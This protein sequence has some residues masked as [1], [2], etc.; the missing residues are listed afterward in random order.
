M[1]HS[2]CLLLSIFWSEAYSPLL[3]L[4]AS[5]GRHEVHCVCNARGIHVYLPGSW[6][7]ACISCS[8]GVSA[9]VSIFLSCL[10]ALCLVFLGCPFSFLHMHALYDFV[11]TD[12]ALVSE[13]YFMPLLSQL[14]S[15]PSF[16]REPSRRNFLIVCKYMNSALHSKQIEE[17]EVSSEIGLGHRHAMN[18]SL[19]M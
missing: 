13:D 9:G 17:F 8:S 4:I 12:I 15:V 19:P 11:F 6:D 2:K 7:C 5:P 3:V 18:I 14:Q 1:Y 10:C 16:Q